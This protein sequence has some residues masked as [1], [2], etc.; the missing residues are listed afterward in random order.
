MPITDRTK[1]KEGGFAQ[2]RAALQ[3]FE[4]DVVSAEFDTWGGK[5]IDE[6]T[7]K[8][9]PPRE[10]LE[11]EC[12]NNVVL[13]S[14]EELSMDISE[15]FSFRV[16]CAEATGS[17]WDKFLESA[18]KVKLLVPDDI[19]NKRI[20]WEKVEVPGSS[21]KYTTSIFIID[22]VVGAVRGVGVD[23]APKDASQIEATP[24]TEDPMEVALGL[25]IGKTEAQFRSAIGLHPG[26]VESPLLPLAKAGTITKLL[27]DEGKLVEVV[28]GDKTVY[29]KPE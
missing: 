9:V 1:L 5:L 6:D 23:E 17:P 19:P 16:N 28:E 27:V 11:V 10:F 4:G 26:F 14:T 25:A 15:R 8:P 22:K 3:K 7:G 29:K 20:V 21:P 24:P 2:V 13:E 18:G 12:T